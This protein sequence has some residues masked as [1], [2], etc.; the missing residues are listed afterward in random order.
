MLTHAPRSA[1]HVIK[2]CYEG[3]FDGVGGIP[4]CTRCVGLGAC[5]RLFLIASHDSTLV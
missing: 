4:G 5:Q 1:S 2:Q 3:S